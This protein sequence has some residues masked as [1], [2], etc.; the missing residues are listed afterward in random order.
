MSGFNNVIELCDPMQIRTGCSVSLI[1]TSE[2]TYVAIV[3]RTWLHG[4]SS[5]T[6]TSETTD[7]DGAKP[8]AQMNTACSHKTHFKACHF[9]NQR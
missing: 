8:P 4:Y 2:I 3:F 7:G 5:V 1:K 6:I 9:S